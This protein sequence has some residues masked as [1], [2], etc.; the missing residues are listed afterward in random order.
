MF[1]VKSFK[2][3]QKQKK[4]ILF[5]NS[6]ASVSDVVATIVKNLS[7]S[8]HLLFSDRDSALEFMEEETLRTQDSDQHSVSTIALEHHD[9]LI[10]IDEGERRVVTKYLVERKFFPGEV[11]CQEGDNADRMWLLVRGSVSVR[12]RMSDHEGRRIASLA[13]GTIVGELA[14][15]EFG[16]RSATVIADDEVLCYELHAEGV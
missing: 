13:T 16:K 9:F 5:C 11:L 15:I 12:L 1:C 3:A 7:A 14:L 8:D 10:G 2:K 4:R 6:P